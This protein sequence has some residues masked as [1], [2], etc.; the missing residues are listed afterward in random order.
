VAQQPSPDLILLNGKIFTSN[1][2]RPYVEALAIRG[3][4]IVAAGSTKEVSALSG[5]QTKRVDLGGRV[6]IPGINDAHY[7]CDAEPN[8]FHLQF[9]GMDPTWSEV[10]DQLAVAE[11]KAP[12]E[13]LI[14]WRDRSNSP[15]PS[16]GDRNITG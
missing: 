2:A 6:V 11:T 1:S 14:I 15:G 12:K 13:A 7:H 10:A 3:E 9:H 16:G 8:A 4:L 5:P